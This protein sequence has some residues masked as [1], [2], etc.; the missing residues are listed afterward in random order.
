MYFTD[1]GELLIDDG[2]Y[3][4]VV[5]LHTLRT[6][7]TPQCRKHAY[8]GRD[9]HAAEIE[10]QLRSDRTAELARLAGRMV[11]ARRMWKPRIFARCRYRSSRRD[12]AGHRHWASKEPTDRSALHGAD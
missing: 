9:A 3:F 10:T 5:D 2:S 8:P 1:R 11:C 6:E 7:Q 4:Y 12:G